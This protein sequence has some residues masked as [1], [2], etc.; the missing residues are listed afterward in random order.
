MNIFFTSVAWVIPAGNCYA[1]HE[2]HLKNL[3]LDVI[4]RWPP[5]MNP[6]RYNLV[7]HWDYLGN[8]DF[9]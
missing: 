4:V 1:P 9:F 2:I 6:M 7:T 5:E 8:I 3:Y